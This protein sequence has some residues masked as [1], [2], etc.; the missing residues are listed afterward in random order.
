M[1]DPEK[2]LKNEEEK[3]SAGVDLSGKETPGS[4]GD[5]EATGATGASGATGAEG[6]SGATGQSDDQ[7]QVSKSELEQLRKDAGEKENYRKAVIRLNKARGRNLPGSEPVKKKADEKEGEGVFGEE[8]PKGDFVTRQ[9]LTLRDEKRAVSDACKNEEILLNWDEVIVFYQ[10]PK[11]NTYDTQLAAINTAHK[12]WRNDKGIT[13]KPD[14]KE[15][16]KK[17]AERA[18]QDLASDKGLSK[19]KDKKPTPP[20]KTIMPRKEKM[21]NWYK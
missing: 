9:E 14:E 15:E 21:E 1:D 5:D 2:D 4:D 20:K 7:V 12:L 8:K 17:K 6:A 3:T 18:K 16:E 19:G 11:E 13:D 10:R